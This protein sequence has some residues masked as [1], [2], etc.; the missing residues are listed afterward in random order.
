MMR[1]KTLVS[2][3]VAIFFGVLLAAPAQAQQHRATRLGN[4]ATRFA[5][6]LA[7]PEDLRALFCNEKLKADV[8]II[9]D[10]EGWQGDDEDLRRA[11]ATAE[12]VEWPITPGTILPFMSS[13]EN[14]KPIA[15]REVLWAGKEPAPAYAFVFVSKGRLCRCITPKACSNFLVVDLGPAWVLQLTWTA[16]GEASLCEPAEMRLVVRN[17]G[18]APLTGTRVTGTLPAGLKT[19]DNQTTL[20][21]IAGT[22]Q[23]GEGKTC[24]FKAMATA[25]GTYAIQAR[26]TSAEGASVDAETTTLFHAPAL[27]ITCNAP[28]EVLIGRPAELCLTVRNTGDAPDTN[29]NLTL[30]IPD[31]ATLVSTTP[32]GAVADGRLVWEFPH[33]APQAT[34]TVCAVFT[35]RRPGLLAFA[36]VARGACAPAVESSCA[37]RVEGVAGILLEMVDLEDPVE[38]G[39]EVTYDIKITNQGSATIGNIQIVCTVPDG[40]EF[41]SGSGVTPVAAQGRTLTMEPL[42]ALA[43]KAVASWRVV[44]KALAAGDMRFRVA[45]TAD[46]FPDPILKH[47]STT[48]F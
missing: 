43:G 26:A 10:Q 35:L 23:P 40:Q 9:L 4:P 25:P 38:V 6:P 41:L 11:A 28:G 22:L 24:L 39:K 36:P 45:L 16:P 7:H 21:F 47:E 46:L 13:R 5:P 31:G 1:F 14:G 17:A 8:A 42:P 30:P 18:T 2:L 12:I 29:V 44:V 3:G 33:L 32:V 15:L 20:N 48:Q 27:A 19:S 37:T 34:Q